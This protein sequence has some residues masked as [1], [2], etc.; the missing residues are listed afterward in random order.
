MIQ[1]KL[2]EVDL[3]RQTAIIFNICLVLVLAIANIAFEWRSYEDIGKIDLSH[4]EILELQEWD[5]T[6]T[7][8][9]VDGENTDSPAPDIEHLDDDNEIVL[10]L[11]W[12][13]D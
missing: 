8:P 6:Y 12:N 10:V 4:G 9:T 5:K 2:P 1:K 3:S 11:D 13:G 7:P